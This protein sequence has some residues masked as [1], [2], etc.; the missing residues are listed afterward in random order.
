MKILIIKTGA[1]GDVV[2]TTALLN[3]LEGEIY[4]E[5]SPEY[6]ALLPGNIKIFNRRDAVEFDLVISL[7]ETAKDAKLASSIATKKLIGIYWENNR[8][9]YTDDSA[10]WFDMSLV[11]RLGKVAAN[12]LKKQNQHS[13]QHFLFKMLD[14]N[15]TAERY[16]LREVKEVKG[17][18]GKKIIGIEKRSGSMWPNKAWSGYDELAVR[19]RQAGR[20]VKFFEQRENILQYM[21]DVAG[22]SCVVSGDT[23]AMHLA[24][25]YEIPCV[26]LFNCTSPDEIYEY[27]LL[28]KVISPMLKEN[29]YSREYDESVINSIPVQTVLDCVLSAPPR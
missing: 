9:Q 8:I 13:F 4:W 1:A 15:F 23:L 25:A 6:D 5:I 28:K 2:R 22:C 18:K 11:S 21:E 3:V 29:F 26:A 12:E 10:G 17:G 24:L 27:G 16:L 7:E 19:L 20:E 14:R